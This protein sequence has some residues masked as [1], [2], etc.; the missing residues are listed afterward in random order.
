MLGDRLLA[1]S[2]NL[3]PVLTA[4]WAGLIVNAL[5]CL[6][7]GGS[8]APACPVLLF[9]QQVLFCVKQVLGASFVHCKVSWMLE[10]AW[11]RSGSSAAVAQEKMPVRL[12][13]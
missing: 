13:S 10:S 3:S 1:D 5:N 2:V 4:G 7:V 12:V 8:P 11:L 6:P 9:F